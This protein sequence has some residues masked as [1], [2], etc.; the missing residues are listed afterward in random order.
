MTART[1]QTHRLLRQTPATAL[2]FLVSATLSLTLC[3]LPN[4]NQPDILSSFG[5][6]EQSLLWQGE[7]WRLLIN[8][9]L[10]INIF[11]FLFNAY[12]LLHFGPAVERI[13][14]RRFYLASLLCSAWLIGTASQLSWEAGGIG[15][16]GLIYFLFAVLWRLRNSEPLA[17]KICD[18][19]TCNLLWIW[20]ILIGPGL[21]LAGLVKVGNLVHLSGVICGLLTA[22]IYRQ[23][24]R[25]SQPLWA[26]G[27][28][29]PTLALILSSAIYLQHPFMDPDWHYWTAYN[30]SS[31]NTQIEHYR[32]AL[33]IDPENQ[34]VRYNL[35][36]SYYQLGDIKQAEKLWLACPP[37]HRVSQ[38]L[39]ALYA[40]QGDTAGM[41][42]WASRLQL[43]AR[44]N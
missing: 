19:A 12:W 23:R 25:F 36:L 20:L 13:L 38:A 44:L 41:T 10:H 21:T 6:G 15:L 1:G 5:W 24:A 31:P 18:P 37:D 28:A 11:H 4:A 14:G 29:V 43:Q 8:N 22:E 33:D 9:I 7:L 2:L 42:R 39:F 17:K 40:S 34:R 27:L 35:A 16:S 26:M 30:S 32:T 3:F